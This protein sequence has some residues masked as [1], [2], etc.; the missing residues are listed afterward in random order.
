MSW[1]GV[2]ERRIETNGIAL[3]IAEAGAPDA[4]L[5]LLI[6]GFPESWYSWR[7]QFAPLAAAG[8]HVVAPDMRG[9]GKS[10]KP[11]AID[12]YNQVEIVNDII[13]LI[14]AL[15]YEQAVVI[16]HDWGAP[17][18]WATALFHPDK[19]RAVGGL[20]VPFMPRSPVQP[21]PA[22]R[23]MFKGQFFYQLYFQE[24]GVAEAE[25]EKDIRRSLR[26]FLVMAAGET[27]LTKLPPK[28]EHD[29]LLSN[30]PDPEVLPAWLSE[31]D[32]DFY[33]GEFA[34]SG[35]RG[36]LNYYR[37][38]DLTWRLTHGAPTQIHQPAMFVAGAADG[39][40]MMAA[41]A[42]AALPQTVTDLRI[43][44]MIPGIGHWTQQEAPE[45][46]N[47]AIL[48]FLKMVDG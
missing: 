27:D 24:P 11:E 17:T 35:M 28:S 43:N 25:F 37:N 3:N 32:L 22:M 36:P 12:A 1:E 18:A 7:H 23:E 2:T 38:F 5:V 4:P 9:Y 48:E 39:V 13:G 10:D 29:D 33:A 45:A 41:A 42:I 34:R 47:E 31:A 44:R 8:Y 30:L 46:V 14:P 6:H 15:G 16:G 26:K 21:M 40:V 19:V 20:S